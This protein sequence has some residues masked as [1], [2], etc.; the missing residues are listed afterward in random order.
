MFLAL[1]IGNS[2]IKGGL[3]EGAEAVRVFSIS[4]EPNG[5]GRAPPDTETL[6]SHLDDVT[7]EQVG[8][9]SVVP[10]VTT[11][12]T[13]A[14]RNQTNAPI[15]LVRSDMPLP[16]AMNYETP[17]TL[18]ADRLAAAA[19]GWIQYGQAIP[20]S[21][22]VVDIGSAV[23]YEV[24]HRDGLYEGGAIGPGPALIRWALRSGT[25]QLPEITLSLPEQA[26]GRSTD[27]ALR[28]GIMWGLIDSVRGMVDRLAEVLPDDP[29]VVLT[30]GWS[31]RL[32]DHLPR[33]D[34]AAPH[35][36]LEGARLLTLQSDS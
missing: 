26:T 4:M 10:A 16:F 36:V 3:F 28:S 32:A 31:A 25:A 27:E 21:V 8:L 1:D 23:N 34:H 5:S 33:T 18:G 29:I 6:I 12:V 20:R 7:V 14:L 22:L 13:E 19:A 35:L 17:R 30:G 24:V 15:T 9:V 2:A 11:S